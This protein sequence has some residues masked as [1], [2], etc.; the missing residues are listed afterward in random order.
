MSTLYKLLGILLI[1]GGLPLFWTPIPIGLILITVGLALI[2][3]NSDSMRGVVR[4]QRAKHDGFDRWLCKAERVVPHPFDRI[5]ERTE[6][7]PEDRA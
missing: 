2:I 7:S 5:L 4:R 1:L 3:A 6:V